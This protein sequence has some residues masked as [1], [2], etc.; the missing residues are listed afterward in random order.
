MLTSEI[1]D[2]HR[3]I[4]NEKKVMIAGLLQEVEKLNAKGK[5]TTAKITRLQADLGHETTVQQGREIELE[6]LQEESKER[7]AL[8]KQLTEARGELEKR[9]SELQKD[10]E[11]QEVSSELRRK[12]AEL[13]R[14]E[15]E[16]YSTRGIS[17]RRPM[18]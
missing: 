2:A 8:L 15:S 13:Q 10:S 4:L 3:D 14:K 18:R 16:L 7:E 6:R 5:D 12:E 11:L 9:N 17:R 1:L